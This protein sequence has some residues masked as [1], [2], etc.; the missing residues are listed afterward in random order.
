MKNGLKSLPQ[1]TF[2]IAPFTLE[3]AVV[4]RGGLPKA[5]ALT[6]ANTKSVTMTTGSRKKRGLTTHIRRSVGACE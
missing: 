4:V 6:S 1:T 5:T 3:V 2:P